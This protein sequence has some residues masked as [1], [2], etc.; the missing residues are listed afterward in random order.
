MTDTVD[1]VIK[2]WKKV[3]DMYSYQSLPKTGLDIFI[4]EVERLR[5]EL[6]EI[7]AENVGLDEA[8]DRLNAELAAAKAASRCPV[9]VLNI[10]EGT[11]ESDR[12][13]ELRTDAEADTFTDWLRERIKDTT[14]PTT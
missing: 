2:K 10:F 4:D 7:K 8:H 14:P 1:E 13:I 9:E 11:Y 5:A 6:A 12:Y 3:R